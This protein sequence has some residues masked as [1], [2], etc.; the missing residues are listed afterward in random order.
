VHN[1]TI[2]A[3][4]VRCPSA[5]APARQVSRSNS[6]ARTATLTVRRSFVGIPVGIQQTYALEKPI[7][8]RE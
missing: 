5:M 1:W 6:V 7:T 8:V 2:Q 4:S 3:D